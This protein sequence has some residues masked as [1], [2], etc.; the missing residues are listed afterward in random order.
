MG[1]VEEEMFVCGTVPQPTSTTD[2]ITMITI[3]A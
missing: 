1:V 3:V 2:Q